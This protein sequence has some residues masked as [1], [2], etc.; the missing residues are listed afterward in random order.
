MKAEGTSI[1][2]AKLWSKEAGAVGFSS[3]TGDWDTPQEFFDK[4]DNQFHFN[5][6]PCATPQSAK[7]KKYFTEEDDGLTQDW[8]GRT[9][10]VNP[11]Y[12]RDIGAWIKKGYEESKKH[13]TLVVMLIPSRTDTKWWHDY[14]MKAKEIHL[15]RGRLKFGGSTNAAPFPS[16]VV[17]FHSDTLYRG[18]TILSP[19]L[20]PME[21]T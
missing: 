5:L 7:C 3:K 8:K 20:Y 4:L 13:N 10:F 12:G 19:D 2:G 15:V 11:P 6:D 17:V 16:A 18:P 14:V 1:K 9:V 21:R